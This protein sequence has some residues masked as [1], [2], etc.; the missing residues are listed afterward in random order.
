L[1]E[2]NVTEIVENSPVEP[3]NETKEALSRGDT[4]KGNTNS[5]ELKK[6]M[7]ISREVYFYW[8]GNLVRRKR[9]AIAR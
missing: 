9:S 6:K 2:K 5:C 7:K 8:E 1:E 4:K 3:K